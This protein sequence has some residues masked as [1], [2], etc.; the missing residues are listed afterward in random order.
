M[1]FSNFKLSNM[2]ANFNDNSFN[3]TRIM[4]KII[5]YDNTLDDIY[6]NIIK[7]NNTDLKDNFCYDFNCILISLLE[8]CHGKLDDEIIE[9]YKKDIINI[10]NIIK[11][12]NFLKIEFQNDID[13]H[14]NSAIS[15]EPY[16]KDIKDI[17]EIIKKE[18]DI[19]T[20]EEINKY[21][22]EFYKEEN[23]ILENNYKQ[24]Y[25]IFN[26]NNYFYDELWL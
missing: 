7:S 12:I 19:D 23:T 16:I 15:Q 6:S 25:D 14:L 20:D 5:N 9:K 8:L 3:K 13:N 18:L 17:K 11:Y 21:D 10:T 4:F 1:N 22:I 26:E 24:K 2:S